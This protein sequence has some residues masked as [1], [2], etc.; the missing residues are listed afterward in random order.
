MVSSGDRMY[1]STIKSQPQV[2]KYSRM[3]DTDS[4]VFPTSWLMNGLD[5]SIG[6]R[7]QMSYSSM[8][9]IAST[10]DTVNGVLQQNPNEDCG[11][12]ATMPTMTTWGQTTNVGTVTLGNV[13]VY[14]PKN[15]SGGN[16]NCARY[17]Y[18]SISIDSS[19]AFGY[20]DDITRGPTLADLSL[21]YTADPSKRML[22]GKTFTGGEQQPLD[23]PCRRGTAAL[24]D[25][26]YNCP[27]P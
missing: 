7:W 25:P 24:G 13:G 21:F 3:I 17:Y 5:N 23:T 18:F 19:Q 26:N 14:T 10:T 9:D 4:D 15:S 8:H 1:S 16:I 20:P 12:S 2:A 6:A 22:H 27:L 11:T